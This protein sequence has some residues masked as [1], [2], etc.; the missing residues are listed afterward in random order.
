MEPQLNFKKLDEDRKHPVHDDE[1]TE[2]EEVKINC[3]GGVQESDFDS[4]SDDEDG[5]DDMDHE[6]QQQ[7]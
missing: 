3:I 1:E 5:R 4:D 7:R 6:E 2:D